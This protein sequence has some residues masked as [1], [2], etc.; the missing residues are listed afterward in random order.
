MPDL[1]SAAKILGIQLYPENMPQWAQDLTDL[2][3]EDHKIFTPKISWKFSTSKGQPRTDLP[4]T[5]MSSYS[6]G[7]SWKDE[8]NNEFRI[9]IAEGT[10]IKHCK[11][12]LLHE[13]AHQI[14]P[15]G[16]HHGELFWKCAYALYR[17]YG[18]NMRYAYDM[19]KGYKDMAR[20]IG[21]EFL[22]GIW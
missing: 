10:D 1:R 5:G 9:L 7:K 3:C 11:L 4:Q 12:I 22:A 16:E 21:A 2:V 17:R 6:N 13:L 20:T 18:L 8:A 14:M 19:E 15:E